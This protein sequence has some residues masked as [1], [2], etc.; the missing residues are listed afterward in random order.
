VYDEEKRKNRGEKSMKGRGERR[1]MVL[2]REALARHRVVGGGWVLKKAKRKLKVG[3]GKENKRV[4]TG[5][6]TS[7]YL[8]DWCHSPF[9]MWTGKVI[10]HTKK[11]ERNTRAKKIMKESPATGLSIKEES[12]LPRQE[13]SPE[14]RS[15]EN[16][17]SVGRR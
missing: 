8:F 10:T 5:G 6:E 16:S 11:R 3:T 1:R 15:V 7:G 17:E 12:L 13:I 4:E 2:R 9:R 14:R